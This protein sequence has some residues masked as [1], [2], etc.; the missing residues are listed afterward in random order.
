MS[1]K[2][3]ER[4]IVDKV[5]RMCK[6]IEKALS[7]A[8]E[9][10]L[11][12]KGK[13]DRTDVDTAAIEIDI[14]RNDIRDERVNAPDANKMNALADLNNVLSSIRHSFTVWSMLTHHALVIDIEN[15]NKG[16][17][18]KWFVLPGNVYR[19]MHHVFTYDTRPITQGTTAFVLGE[20]DML[21]MSDKSINRLE[22][23]IRGMVRRELARIK[24]DMTDYKALN[25]RKGSKK[26][27]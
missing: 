15:K 21:A 26:N 6:L 10:P 11:T 7:V 25:K 12:A 20:Y 27:V 1:T 2:K 4:T 18:E 22:Q 5:G 9:Q 23:A 14:V 3:L 24:K 16:K 17:Y 19:S 8:T 13:Y